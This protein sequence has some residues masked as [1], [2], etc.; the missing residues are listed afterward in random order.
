MENTAGARQA[1]D[2]AVVLGHMGGY[3]HVG[4]AIAMAD[5][6]L[7]RRLPALRRILGRRAGLDVRPEHLRSPAA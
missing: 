7:V 4:D 3:F 5:L 6:R 1:P 2:T